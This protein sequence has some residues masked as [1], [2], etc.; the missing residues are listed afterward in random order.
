METIFANFM[1][2]AFVERKKV[3]FYK[4]SLAKCREIM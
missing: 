1:R 3:G 2:K 4:N